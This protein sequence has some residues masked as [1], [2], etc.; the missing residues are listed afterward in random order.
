LWGPQPCHSAR[1]FRARARRSLLGGRDPRNSRFPGSARR[2]AP[3]RTGE[4]P[5]GVVVQPWTDRSAEQGSGTSWPH[6]SSSEHRGRSFSAATKAA[7][8]SCSVGPG[9]TAE[10]HSAA[11]GRPAPAEPQRLAAKQ[12]RGAL[13]ADCGA[14]VLVRRSGLGSRS[15]NDGIEVGVFCCGFAHLCCSPQP[16]DLASWTVAETERPAVRSAR[17]T[18]RTCHRRGHEFFQV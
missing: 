13:G 3:D 1:H 15:P 10:R 12:V 4:L 14:S 2:E 8:V 9:I 5:G 7:V 18:E 6:G 11:R 16:D 17:A